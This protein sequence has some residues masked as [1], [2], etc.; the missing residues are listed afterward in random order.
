MDAIT[1][2][3]SKEAAGYYTYDVGPPKRLRDEAEHNRYRY[4]TVSER[5]AIQFQNSSKQDDLAECLLQALC[6]VK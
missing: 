3:L 2:L 4:M 1:S 5:L 6:F